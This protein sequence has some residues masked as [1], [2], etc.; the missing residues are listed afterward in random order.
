MSGKFPVSQIWWTGASCTGNGYLNDA[1]GS[2]GGRVTAAKRVVFS[3]QTN[4][5]WVPSGSGASIT[6]AS[7]PG[8]QSIENSGLADGASTC[9]SEPG[10]EGGW[11]LTPLDA[12][13]ALGWTVSGSPLG[14]AG[15]IKFQ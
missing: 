10:T 2:N 4:T 6:S 11:L 14:V 15:P 3:G 1:N 5:L 12:A 9:T 13:T 8:I 7:A